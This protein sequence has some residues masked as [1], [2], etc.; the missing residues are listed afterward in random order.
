MMKIPISE[1]ASIPPKTGVPT[2]RR[3]ALAA[4]LAITSGTRPRMKAT[5]VI[6]TA[7]S[8]GCH[9]ISTTSA[10]SRSSPR[11]GRASGRS[12]GTKAATRAKATAARR[13]VDQ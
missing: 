9:A 5:E 7:R 3:D 12:P 13:A 1:A 10:E 6:I 8:C 11:E 2:A 4:P